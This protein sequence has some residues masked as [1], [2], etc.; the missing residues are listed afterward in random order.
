MPTSRAERW[1]LVPVA[2]LMLD[3]DAH[4][5]DANEELVRLVG[6]TD[7]EEVLGRR[8]GELLTVGG[9][10]FW[11][12]HLAPL[13]HVE[14]R[15][16]E[17]AVELR[18]PT[19]REP[20]LLTAVERS[21]ESHRVIEAAMFRARE[22]TRFE[23]EL[24]DARRVAETAERRVR[25]LH[26]NAADLASVAGRDGVAWAML[27]NAVTALG[28]GDAA[29]WVTDEGGLTYWGGA[30]EIPAPTVDELHAT[31]VRP[32]GDVVV[33]LRTADQLLGVL[34]LQPRRSAS[35]DP[36]EPELLAAAGQQAALALARAGLHEQS[37]SVA[38]ELQR[39]MLAGALSAD[40]HVEIAAEYRPG[41]H[42]LQVGGDWYDTYRTTPDT[43]ALSVGDVV[44]RGLGAATAMGQ[45]RTASRAVADPAAGPE[46]VL[47][48]LD[49]F[50]AGTGTGFMA[51]L[52]YA[53]LDLAT[54]ALRYACA[55]H[56]PPLHLRADGDTSFLWHARSTPLGVR[57]S[58]ARTADT[59]LLDPG[60]VL[61]L[62]TDGIVERRDRALSTELD[63]LADTA[64]TALALHGSVDL[65]ALGLVEDAPEHDDACV[66]A[67]RWLGP[68]ADEEGAH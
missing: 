58:S 55:G 44:G 34:V 49:R 14:G 54:G 31:T 6:A 8:L 64:R 13:L 10:I 1:N 40:E 57:G 46:Q 23:H 51:S 65:L 59:V 17:V 36:L 25:T 33:P 39:A 68:S 35:A 60:D 66:L 21:C 43:L 56:L 5:L 15:V 52:V 67:I 45:L 47:D 38:A 50:V 22:R 9:R 3:G 30:V 48:R 32:D 28:A 2:L 26:G 29:L 61:V 19:G 37:V 41:V 12:T 4:V 42:E 18:T 16:D 24:V 7:V 11:E 20:V 27:R 63:A 53:Q 62:Y